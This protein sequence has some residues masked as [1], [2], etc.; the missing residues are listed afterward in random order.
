MAQ[1]E[2]A[3]IVLC[4]GLALDFGDLVA[5]TSRAALNA[6]RPTHLLDVLKAL[7]RSPKLFMYFAKVHN[8]PSDV[9]VDSLRPK[10]DA[11]RNCSGKDQTRGEENSFP[12]GSTI[13]KIGICVKYIIAIILAME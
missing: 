13:A 8:L 5:S 10:I 4:G 6:I 2:P 11:N 1:I 3:A 9:N 7:F 12:H